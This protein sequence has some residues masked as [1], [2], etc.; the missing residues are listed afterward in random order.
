M[1]NQ[2]D[3]SQP[4]LDGDGTEADQQQPQKQLAPAGQQANG[5]Q[6]NDGPTDEHVNRQVFEANGTRVFLTFTDKD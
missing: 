2:V 1:P 3:H 5:Q 4:E 6:G